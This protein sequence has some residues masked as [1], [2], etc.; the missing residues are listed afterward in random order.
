MKRTVFDT[1]HPLVAA[2]YLSAALIFP[3]IALQPVYLAISLI[4]AVAYNIFLRGWQ[5]T[6][7]TLAWQL[8]LLAAIAIINP[9]FSQSGSTVLFMWGGHNAFYLESLIYGICMGCMLITVMQWFSNF[10]HIMTSDKIMQLTGNTMPTIGLMITMILRLVPQFIRRNTAVRST[11][12]AC[13]AAP[14]KAASSAGSAV[15]ERSSQSFLSRKAEP[16]KH[17]FRDLSVLMG[18]GMEDSLETSEAMRARGWG[19]AEKRTTYQR[20]DLRGVDIVLL[21]IMGILVVGNAFLAWVACSQFQ[22][23]PTIPHLT[24]WWGYIPY[25]L[26]LIIP[27]ILE[28]KERI[29]WNR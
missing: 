24:L 7:R 25:A 26:F 18:W 13:T 11:Q 17:Y 15:S 9:L 12:Q 20:S 1:Y 21:I 10:S 16:V 19:S 22:F 28:L 5:A 23:Y 29:A 27:V 6:A 2:L 14:P 4:F 3:M 8:V